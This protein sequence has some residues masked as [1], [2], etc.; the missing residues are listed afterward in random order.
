LLEASRAAID[1]IR[2]IVAIRAAVLGCLA[3]LMLPVG[4]VTL[5]S[6]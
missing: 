6:A 5:V 2:L 1:E 4:I 3:A